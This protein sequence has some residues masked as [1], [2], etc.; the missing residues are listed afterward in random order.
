M[1]SFSLSLRLI[2][3]LRSL[4]AFVST[5]S[6][7]QPPPS[8]QQQETETLDDLIGAVEDTLSNQLLLE[9]QYPD[10]NPRIWD[11]DLFQPMKLDSVI[12]PNA[13]TLKARLK[14]RKFIKHRYLGP[15][16]SESRRGDLFYQLGIDPLSESLNCNLLSYYLSDM[17]RV[18]GRAQTGLTWQSQRR[19]TKAIRRAKMMGIIPLHSKRPLLKG[20]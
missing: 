16:A 3:R 20:Y 5:S 10:S 12:V 14:Q 8:Q 17:G 7:T 9:P 2:P 4:R 15:S 13:F 1:F 19:L 11:P 18:Q 6:L